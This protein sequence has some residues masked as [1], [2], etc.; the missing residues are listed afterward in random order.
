MNHFFSAQLYFKNIFSSYSYLI[1][2]QAGRELMNYGWALIN[3]ITKERV[4]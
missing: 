3:I 4:S 2:Q 1:V